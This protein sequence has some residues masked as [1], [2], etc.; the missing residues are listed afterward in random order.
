[1]RCCR[2]R[3]P[4]RPSLRQKRDL[5]CGVWNVHLHVRLEIG[6]NSESQPVVDVNLVA[7]LSDARSVAP[8]YTRTIAAPKLSLLV[9]HY[10]FATAVPL[11]TRWILALK[12]QS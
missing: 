9:R 8:N 6:M 5:N 10:S 7:Q 4:V 12:V 2:F 11:E 1:M 3:W